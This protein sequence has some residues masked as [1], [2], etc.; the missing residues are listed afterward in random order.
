LIDFGSSAFV[1]P[2][3]KQFSTFCGTLD[4]AAPEILLGQKYD[5]PPQDVWAM[6]ILLYTLVYKENPFYN[7]DEIISGSLRL[8][9]HLS[10]SKI[11]K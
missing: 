5:G 6:G 11:T 1:K 4:Y 8:P 7:M 2:H 3:G 10:N 9:F